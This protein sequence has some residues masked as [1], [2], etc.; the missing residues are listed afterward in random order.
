MGSGETRSKAADLLRKLA[1]RAHV[2]LTF[3]RLWPLFV[4]LT[5]CAVLFVTLSWAGLW[6]ALPAWGRIAGVALFA[7]SIPLIFYIFLRSGWPTYTQALHRID[8]DSEIPHRP[9]STLSDQLANRTDDPATAALWA[10]HQRRIAI[11]AQNL[12]LAPPSPRMAHKDRYAFRAILFVALAASAFLAGPEKVDRIAAAFDW[13]G[14]AATAASFRF[15]AWIDPPLYT[16]KAPILLN[17]KQSQAGALNAPRHLQAPEGSILVIRSSEANGLNVSPSGGAVTA[18]A[19]PA[20]GKA[21]P[22]GEYRYVLKSDAKVGVKHGFSTLA[23][24][25]IEVIPDHPPTITLL[26]KPV[27]DLHGGL[28]VRYKTNDDYGVVSAEARF[29]NPIIGNRKITGRTLVDPPKADLALPS[30]PGGLGDGETTIN[31]T[32]H[33]WAG[34]RVTMV[35]VARDD[36]GQEG[37]SEEVTVQLPQRTFTNPLAK[38]LVEQRR[39]LILDPDNA[40]HVGKAIATLMLAPREMGTTSSIYLGLATAQ[41]RLDHAKTDA[42]LRDVADFLWAMALDLEGDSTSSALQNLRAA[43]QALRDA[44]QNGASDEEIKQLMKQLQDAMDAYI[45][46][47]NRRQAN[48]EKFD[49][50][51]LKK[52]QI[53]TQQDL[54]RL[55]D[56]LQELSQSGNRVDAQRMLDQMENMLNNLRAAGPGAPGDNMDRNMNEAMNDLDK[57]LH[58]QEQL[59]DDTYRQGQRNQNRQGM[60]QNPF[61]MPNGQTP[62]GQGQQG[63]GPNGM[64]GNSGSSGQQSLDQRQQDLQQRLDDLKRRMKQLGMKGVPDFDEAQ[65]GMGDAENA[66][67]GGPGNERQALDAEGRALD[68]LRR[69]AQ[70]LNDQMEKQR[71]GL[72]DGPNGQGQQNQSANGMDGQGKPTDPLGRTFSKDDMSRGVAT[73]NGNTSVEATPAQRAMKIIEELRNRLGDRSRA[74]EELDY[75]ERLMQPY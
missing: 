35:L 14:D 12:T 57:M 23:D 6:L 25:D 59:R 63:K 73:G 24:Y 47:L 26:G 13:S 52:Q 69:G 8:R 46:D 75:L 29:K 55:M 27:P 72:K 48:G 71:E 16:G 68:A 2:V 15:D 37:R 49:D 11:A 53:I 36:P 38:A 3:E 44:L 5:S 18:A 1:L 64:A 10:L 61:G 19:K 9:A 62:N 66:L 50:S 34:A 40:A 33:P 54:K 41:T 43:E 30:A 42:D 70:A 67:K 22:A 17:D 28:T 32:D 58:D 20:D 4:T 21:A 39:N 45:A 7:L 56:R 51:E 65:K 74:Q 31:L 60:G